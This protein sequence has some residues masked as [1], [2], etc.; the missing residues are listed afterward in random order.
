MDNWK[1]KHEEFMKLIEETTK[2]LDEKLKKGEITQYEYDELKTL[3][4]EFDE[5]KDS[6]E[7]FKEFY[8]ERKP[9][10]C[11]ELLLVIYDKH[12][13]SFRKAVLLSECFP[14]P[15]GFKYSQEIHEF[16]ILIINRA[17]KL[18]IS[19]EYPKELL[20]ELKQLYLAL[21][22]F[23]HNNLRNTE[24]LNNCDFMKF[25]LSEQIRMLFI[26]LQDQ[27]RLVA[28]LRKKE[29]KKQGFFTGMESAISNK[30]TNTNLNMLISYEDNFEGIL[31]AYDIL[32]RYLYF[33]KNKDYK[34][35]TIP[36]HGDITHIRIPSLELITKLSIQRNLLIR[37]WEKFKYS[38]WNVVIKND[39]AQDVYIFMPKVEEEY[40]E[41][42]IAS[43]RRQYSLMLNLFKTKDTEM[44][45]ESSRII[46]KISG[47]INKDDIKTLFLMS[48][49]DYLIAAESY[50]TMINAYKFNMHSY[51]LE[52]A[53]EGF[54]IEDIF[55]VFELLH[56]L[57]K[58]YKRAIYKD[59]DQEDNAWYKYLCPIVPIDYFIEVLTNYYG[60]AKEYSLK[61]IKCFTFE[62][63]I[64]GESDIFSRPLILVNSDNIVFCPILMQQ[65][66]LE[67]IIE[68]LLSNFEVN[69]AR[70]GKDFEN[71]IKFI[72]SHFSGIKVNTSKIEF[73]ASDGRNI[74]F[75]FIG[76][77]DNHLLLW[78]FKAMTVP[79]SDKKHM[80]CKKTIMECIDQI[81]RRSHIIKT[82]WKKIKELANIELPEK[83]FADDKIIKL[84]GTNIFD[85]TT[86]VYGENI[87][88][89]DEST[90][91]KFFINPEVKVMS[92]NDKKVLNSK[93]L[94]KN[95]EPTANEFIHYLENPITT[96][97]YMGCIE[98]FPKAFDVFED[99][100]P[101]AIIDQILT[102]DPYGQE[103]ENSIRFNKSSLADKKSKRKKSSKHRMK[104]RKKKK[105]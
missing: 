29:I 26:F 30:C 73:L 31:E 66:N 16:S 86:L 78:E 46:S 83:P 91:L 85:F 68:M 42:I 33:K 99:D 51:Y 25:S 103:I 39:N 44:V 104:K 88:V 2:L 53:I 11:S 50:Q 65:I 61:L 94:W 56:V 81:E 10:K 7:L 28:E 15:L 40:K 12:K 97:P 60:F 101:F 20:I 76:T 77:F 35:K 100:Y 57:A 96:S 8:I 67:R 79:Y 82:D 70:I 62:S 92:L 69:I 41:H 71:R 18:A 36:E 1:D 14:D 22:F 9:I 6:I 58:C 55:R 19:K 43:N 89:V 5:E 93:R 49:E 4:F 87:R 27:D 48:K 38:Q 59:F 37:T 72:L 54:R 64:K 17:F 34:N 75:D 95:T 74:E 23:N 45:H 32:I 3:D 24:K 63:G 105:K 47:E 52:L 90:L 80:E 102:K 98:A 13:N 84:V 21:N